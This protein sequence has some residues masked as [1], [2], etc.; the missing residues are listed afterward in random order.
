MSYQHLTCE[1]RHTISTLRRN[2]SKPSHIAQQLGRHVS[3]INRELRR[4]ATLEEGYQYRYAHS[5]A[6]QRSLKADCWIERCP[7]ESWIFVVTQ[8]C[9]EQRNPEQIRNKLPKHHLP[10]ISHE[11]IYARIY[12][13]KG[14]R[15]EL[16]QH[17][18][19]KVKSYTNRSLQNDRD[20]L[21]RTSRGC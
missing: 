11:T 14:Y 17:L 20:L 6:R 15:G 16:Y 12:A 5:K 1:G 3:T 4:N 13:D 10:L 19:H 7:A 2:G 8:L 9:A 18:R 21:R